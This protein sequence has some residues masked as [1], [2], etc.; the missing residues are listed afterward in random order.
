L[1]TQEAWEIE[2]DV[3]KEK[4]K[5]KAKDK[6]QVRQ[7][8]KAEEKVKVK[9]KEKVLD[10]AYLQVVRAAQHRLE[11]DSSQKAKVSLHRHRQAVRA[12]RQALLQVDLRSSTDRG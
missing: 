7:V 10:G 2:K 3:Q 1:R 11:E 6:G 12:H 8:P 4:G 5:E 9:E